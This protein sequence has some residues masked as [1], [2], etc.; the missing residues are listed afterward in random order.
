MHSSSH[1]HEHEHERTD[2][3]LT[4][5]GKLNLTNW[6][7][8]TVADIEA[9]QACVEALT[10]AGFADE[11]VLVESTAT[12]LRQLRTAAEREQD[13]NERPLARLM[14]SVAES[15]TGQTPALYDGYV[16]E[17]QAGRTFVGAHDPQ[18]NQI[19]RIRNVFVEH[20][21]RYIHLFEPEDVR[22]LG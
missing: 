17:A 8:G 10:S 16:A 14:H 7:I 13:R 18:G 9:A 4:P 15:F 19:D 12:A 2:L 3:P 21:A 6:V 22:Q 20:G 5:H 11:D 1:E